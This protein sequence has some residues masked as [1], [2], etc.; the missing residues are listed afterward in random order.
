MI[1]KI[2]LFA[3]SLAASFALAFALAAAGF[4]PGATVPSAAVATS[5]PTI[6]EAVPTPQVQVDT[7]YVAA[8]V[9]PKTIKIHKVIA[10]SGGESGEQESGD[11]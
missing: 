1:N 10:S 11:D 5:T 6:A 2:A 3:A 9:K 8:P 4:A 7:V